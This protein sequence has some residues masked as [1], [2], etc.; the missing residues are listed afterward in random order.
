MSSALLFGSKQLS[1]NVKNRKLFTTDI[2][3]PSGQLLPGNKHST[4]SLSSFQLSLP[5]P[6]SSSSLLPSSSFSSSSS[7]SQYCVKYGLIEDG[8]VRKEI[9]GGHLRVRHLHYSEHSLIKVRLTAG[10]APTD[11]KR[12]VI[13]YEGNVMM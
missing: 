10:S 13:K 1:F 4:S 8:D 9:C 2:R 3:F 7:S 11:L 12:Y 5:P 6:S